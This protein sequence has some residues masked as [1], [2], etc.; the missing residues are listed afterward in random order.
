MKLRLLGIVGL[1]LLTGCSDSGES[2]CTTLQ[3]SLNQVR[4]SIY[5]LYKIGELRD[6][7]PGERLES[8]RLAADEYN[9]RMRM[10]EVGCPH[11]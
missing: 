5:E 1:L 11:D 9:L 2:Y 10:D 6:L 8:V 3:T 7:N 4:T